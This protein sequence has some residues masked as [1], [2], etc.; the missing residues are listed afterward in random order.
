LLLSVLLAHVPNGVSISS[1]HQK[2]ILGA[3]EG[4]MLIMKN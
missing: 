4:N 2:Y 3:L 1:S